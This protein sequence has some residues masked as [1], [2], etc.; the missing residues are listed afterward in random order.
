MAIRRPHI[1]S[2]GRIPRA[3]ADARE[4]VAGLIGAADPNEVVFTSCGTESDNWAILGALEASVERD[5]IITTRV[6]HE[7]VRKLCQKLETNGNSVTWLDV[8]EDGE[9]DLEQL[10]GGIERP[11]RD[12]FRHARK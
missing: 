10:A 2:E 12:R 11:Y 8:N 5:H 3:V 4:S 6:E 9:L 7:A 1:C